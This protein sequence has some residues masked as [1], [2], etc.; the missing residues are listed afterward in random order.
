MRFVTLNDKSA[1]NFAIISHMI[2]SFRI[3]LKM[4]KKKPMLKFELNVSSGNIITQIED[5]CHG[6][7]VSIVTKITLASFCH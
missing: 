1:N 6:N 3:W 7:K 4:S 5:C 2:L